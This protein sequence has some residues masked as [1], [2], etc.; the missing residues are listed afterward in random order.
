MYLCVGLCQYD[1]YQGWCY[2]YWSYGFAVKCGFCCQD[3]GPLNFFLWIEVHK[4][5]S[6]IIYAF[7]GS[8]S[9]LIRLKKKMLHAKPISIYSNDKQ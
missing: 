1:I 3:L 9:Q 5:P 4:L 8:I 7:M 6:G 2:N